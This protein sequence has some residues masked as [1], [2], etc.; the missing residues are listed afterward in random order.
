MRHLVHLGLSLTAALGFFSTP[1]RAGKLERPTIT[2]RMEG[3]DLHVIV[4]DVTDYCST[5]ADTHVL[6]TSD[7]IHIVRDRPSRVSECF[8]TKDL[9]FV[10]PDVAP[11]RYRITYE[12]MPLV[13]PAKPR[14]VAWTIALVP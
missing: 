4:H 7:S 8:T 5:N 6:R 2:T 3:R 14:Q 11:G 1:V 13:A 10:V 12:R 9:E